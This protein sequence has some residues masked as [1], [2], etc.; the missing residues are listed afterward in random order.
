[1]GWVQNVGLFYLRLLSSYDDDIWYV[2]TLSDL[3]YDCL[4]RILNF[5]LG[6]FLVRPNVLLSR[7]TV[8]LAVGELVVRAP[9]AP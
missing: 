5:G 1:M 8:S 2:D 9:S 3:E 7:P 6:T 4:N